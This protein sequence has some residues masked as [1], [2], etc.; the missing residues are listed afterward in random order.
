[1]AVKWISTDGFYEISSV[2]HFMCLIRKGSGFEVENGPNDYDNSKFIQTT[3]IDLKGE[4]INP[5]GMGKPVSGI[6]DGS[7]FEIKN[8]SIESKSGSCGLFG[9]TSDDHV[10]KNVKM[11]GVC[12]LKE[13]SKGCSDTWGGVAFVVGQSYG[14]I[15]NVEVVLESGSCFSSNSHNT[16]IISGLCC[17]SIENVKVTGYLDEFAGVRFHGGICGSLREPGFAKS[18]LFAPKVNK[19]YIEK[20]SRRRNSEFMGGLFGYTRSTELTDCVNG[21]IGDIICESSCGIGGIVGFS[22]E[23]VLTRCWNAMTG[24]ILAESS[25]CVGGIFGLCIIPGSKENSLLV[26]VMKGSIYGNYV[27]GLCGWSNQSVVF[28]YVAMSGSVNGEEASLYGSTS[29]SYMKYV[30]WS[31]KF[32]MSVNGLYVDVEEMG[33]KTRITGFRH[34]NNFELPYFEMD[35]ILSD[36]STSYIPN[37]FPNVMEYGEYKDFDYFVAAK[38]DFS[39]PFTFVINSEPEETHQMIKVDFNSGIIFT[40]IKNVNSIKSGF[41]KYLTFS[42]G[43]QSYGIQTKNISGYGATLQWEAHPTRSV[44]RVVYRIKD[45]VTSSMS[46]T[47]TNTL[48][49]FAGDLLPDT[50]YEASVYSSDG[51]VFSIHGSVEFNTTTGNDYSGLLTSIISD[52]NFDLTNITDDNLRKDILLKGGLSLDDEITVNIHGFSRRVNFMPLS[53]SKSLANVRDGESFLIPFE[54]SEGAGQSIN[55]DSDN[56]TQTLVY[57]EESSSVIVSGISYSSGKSFTIGGKKATMTDI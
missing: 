38:N 14:T 48:M 26:N 37:V 24:D 35:S 52:G 53:S 5:I 29:D 39:W 46:R 41:E 32:G 6:Y 1:M 30:Y 2:S 36:K 44:Y 19:F 51:S 54:R 57:D 18:C 15:L 45:D 28:S 50:L 56:G 8:W 20:I 22:R 47:T 55:I 33:A 49:N 4:V 27:G 3:D 40:D 16:G 13:Y 42:S 23:S 25:K 21:M 9:I 12:V 17:G 11:T 31:S 43:L 7:N 34:D 10:I